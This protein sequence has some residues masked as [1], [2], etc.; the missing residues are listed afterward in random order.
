M[1]K[2]TLILVSLCL[3]GLQGVF[4]Q[5][6]LVSGTI[7][8]TEDGK[9]VPGATVLVKGT[10]IGTFT[11]TDGKYALS[12]PPQH[13]VLVVS[14]VGMKTKEVS[15]GDANVLDVAIEPDVMNV[16]EVVVTAIGI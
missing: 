7:T 1:R 10:T 6:R 4:A 2:I 12:V 3:I 16:D 8:S 9:G 14:C 5:G 11:N 13:K 15:L